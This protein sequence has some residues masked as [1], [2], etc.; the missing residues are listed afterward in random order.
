MH[1]QLQINFNFNVEFINKIILS[2]WHVYC[3]GIVKQLI[4]KFSKIYKQFRIIIY[5]IKEHSFIGTLM[6]GW[7]RLD[8]QKPEKIK[9]HWKKIMNEWVW[10][11]FEEDGE[12]I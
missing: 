3:V 11:N 8:F 5:L 2:A 9:Q 10:T 12:K 4:D 1:L 6:K 7:K